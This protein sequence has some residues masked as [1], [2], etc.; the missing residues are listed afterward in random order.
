MQ[1]DTKLIP[2]RFAITGP[3]SSGKSTLAEQ[4]AN[5]FNTHWVPEY[6][7]TYLTFLTRPYVKDDILLIAKRQLQ[8]E[9][10]I[11]AQTPALLFSDTEMIVIKIWYQ[12]FY[13]SCPDWILSAINQNQYKH[14][15]LTA[16]DLP[17]I[18]DGQREHPHLRQYFFELFKTEV[19][20]TG[21]GFTM[22]DGNEKA[23][24]QKAVVVVENILKN[25]NQSLI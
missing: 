12:H 10:E 2:L 3:E 19:Q 9:E 1:T 18:P 5:H 23:R 15:F 17:W 22:I 24:L 25:Q 20:K 8:L 4:L 13:G 21:V 14:Y 6:A 11:A 16:I 7:R